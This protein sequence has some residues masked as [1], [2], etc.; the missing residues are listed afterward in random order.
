MFKK[1][2]QLHQNQN[3]EEQNKKADKLFKQLAVAFSSSVLAL[4][5]S[6]FLI[7]FPFFKGLEK[8]MTNDYSFPI[9]SHIWFAAI[10]MVMSLLGRFIISRAKIDISVETTITASACLAYQSYFVI[11]FL[12]HKG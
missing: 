6:F 2:L 4:G 11:Q 9:T 5:S 7:E 10:F 12:I 8:F 1:Y 3:R